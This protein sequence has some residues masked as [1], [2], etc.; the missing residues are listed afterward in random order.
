MFRL[1]TLVLLSKAYS[2]IPL[3]LAQS[4]LECTPEQVLAGMFTLNP[5]SECQPK[6][7]TEASRYKWGYDASTQ[8]L[9]PVPLPKN[10]ISPTTG[11]PYGQCLAYDVI[12][13]CSP[14]LILVLSGQSTLA[15]IDLIVN[16][17][18][19]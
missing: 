12:C 18:L 1:N 10:A 17:N 7:N 4:Y 19:E 15:T 14:W 16:T 2:S 9:T 8:V 11:A 3:S 5:F 13:I 6:P